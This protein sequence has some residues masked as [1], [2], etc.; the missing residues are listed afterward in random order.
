MRGHLNTDVQARGSN[1]QP[2]DP[3]FDA[4]DRSAIDPRILTSLVL[5]FHA[6]FY[7]KHPCLSF[8]FKEHQSHFAA[9]GTVLNMCLSHITVDFEFSSFKAVK[10]EA[11]STCCDKKK[12]PFISVLA[13]SSV[14]NRKICT[15]YPD[16]GSLKYKLLFNQQ[17]DPRP[18]VKPSNGSIINILFC[19]EG[20]MSSGV[21]FTPNHFVP[22]IHSSILKRKTLDSPNITFKKKI[23][24]S[25]TTNTDNKIQSK[26]SFCHL[27]NLILHVYMPAFSEK[28]SI[29]STDTGNQKLSH[30]SS[31]LLSNSEDVNPLDRSLQSVIGSSKEL[32]DCRKSTDFDISTYRQIVRG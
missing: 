21:T 26:L 2:L 22:L 7:C 28:C 9:F 31:T 4:L 11:L 27:G 10:T 1:S 12:S 25:I 23:Q 32:S 17:I 8:V 30:M 3:E 16:F 15:Y 29:G 5:Y 14:V 13:L 6:D 19:R 24:P 20:P 18:P